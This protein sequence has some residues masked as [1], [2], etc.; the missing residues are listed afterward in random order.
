M[1]LGDFGLGLNGLFG[2]EMDSRGRSEAL[3]IGEHF[4]TREGKFGDE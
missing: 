1:V 3:G 2:E 4:C